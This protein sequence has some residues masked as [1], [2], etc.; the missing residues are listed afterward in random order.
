M[1]RR[2]GECTPPPR[3]RT[4]I[5]MVRGAPKTA[6]LRQSRAR[7]APG[8]PRYFT[9]LHRISRHT[10]STGMTLEGW[11]KVSVFGVP[12]PKKIRGSARG[13][14]GSGLVFHCNVKLQPG[15]HHVGGLGRAGTYVLCFREPAL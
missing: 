9:N 15:L 7:R 12:E 11:M 2:Q 14:S 6:P 10:R 8:R 13:G 4:P 1:R 5:E 3:R